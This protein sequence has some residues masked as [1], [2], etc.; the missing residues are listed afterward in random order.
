MIINAKS[1][2]ISKPLPHKDLSDKPHKEDWNYQTVV[3][4]LTYLQ[5]NSNPDMTMVVLQTEQFS[6]NP[7]LFH[8][9]S[10]NRLGRYLYHNKNEGL[11]YSPYTSK[12]LECYVDADLAGGWLQGDDN[13]ADN[14]M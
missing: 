14:A 6:N 11:F 9:I 12:F 7:M 4:M 3:S 8:D 10:I 13:N 2:P 1:T 5:G